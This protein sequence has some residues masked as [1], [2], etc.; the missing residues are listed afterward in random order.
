MRAPDFWSGDAEG[1]D[2]AP[3]LQA[4]LL[5]LSVVYSAGADARRALTTPYKADAPVVCVGNFTLG[6][7]GKTPI[8]R[9]LRA[10]L[11]PNAHVVA[12]G[13][14]G[15][16]RGP[17][18]VSLGHG[19]DDVGDEPLL[20]ARD[21]A[22]WVSRDRAAGARAAI[23]AGARV[24]LLDDGFQNPT[25]HKDLSVIVVD[26][27][28]GVGNGRVFPSGPLRESLRT[29]LARADA[30][31]LAG[32]GAAPDYLRASGKPLLRAHLAPQGAAPNGKVLAFAGLARPQKFFDTLE[33]LGADI[34]DCVPYPDHHAY[35][36]DEIA[37]L[38]TLA[39]ER[40]A[41]LITTE[42]DHVRL[43]EAD[44]D[45]AVLPVRAVFDDD[46]ALD[47]LLAP[48]RARMEAR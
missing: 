27:A 14:G 18:Q 38:R 44:K 4:V 28:F 17:L 2:R 37:W 9:A 42:K 12:R 32:E 31:V 6:G 21:G 35:S 24:I 11:G 16:A 20:H 48:I 23:A 26:T 34:A 46:A 29:G 15:A 5:P 45:I 13:Y 41:S 36:R 30:F 22:T 33:A 47:A 3:M 8:V 43:S 39:R 10:R 40:G 1:R 7:G 19:A 25:L